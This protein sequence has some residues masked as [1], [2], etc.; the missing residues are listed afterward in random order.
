M[1]RVQDPP[2]EPPGG[3][4]IWESVRRLPTIELRSEHTGVLTQISLQVRNELACKMAPLGKPN[5]VSIDVQVSPE[6]DV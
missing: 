4:Q 3:T 1:V 5:L 6:T 2:P